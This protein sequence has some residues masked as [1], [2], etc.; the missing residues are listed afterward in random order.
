M[1]TS[2]TEPTMT[3]P[4]SSAGVARLWSAVGVSS[5]GDGAFLA[6][7]PL[8]AAAVTRQPTEVAAVTAGMYLP[9]FVVQ[10][11]AGAL[12]ERWPFRATML[13][14]D[15]LRAMGVGGLAVIIALGR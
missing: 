9:W 13:V 2:D 15:F 5:L 7:L 11:V 3:T 8:A 6:A 12:L 4:S 1:A 14:A 10:P